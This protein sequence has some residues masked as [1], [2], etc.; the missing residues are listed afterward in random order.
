MKEKIVSDFKYYLL[1]MVVISIIGYLFYIMM[2]RMLAPVDYGILMTVIGLYTIISPLTSLGFNEALTRFLPIHGEVRTRSY[3][4]YA[5]KKSIIITFVVSTVIFIFSSSIA[6]YFYV[7]PTMTVPLMVLSLMVLTGS[8]SIVL[9]GVLQGTK[10]FS[11]LLIAD[12]ISQSLRLVLPIILIS[13]GVGLLSGLFGWLAAFIVFDIATIIYLFRNF[14][15]KTVKPSDDFIKYGMSS[16]VYAMVLWLLIQNSL[17]IL[18]FFDIAEAGLFSVAL[19]FGQIILALPL[20][21]IGILLP[22][23]SEMF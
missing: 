10:N 9:K 14:T 15:Y 22:H 7:N 19:V 8:L 1:D 23:L 17:L 11:A 12:V 5:L 4:M 16:A 21:L 20:I 2:G 13:Y 6:R 3:M 18:G